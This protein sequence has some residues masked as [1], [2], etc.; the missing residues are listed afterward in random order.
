[1]YIFLSPCRSDAL[2][3]SSIRFVCFFVF[4]KKRE[5]S[6]VSEE[7]GGKPSVLQ[8]LHIKLHQALH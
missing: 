6:K 3:L 8:H 4:F 1:M 7:G 2:R 5:L